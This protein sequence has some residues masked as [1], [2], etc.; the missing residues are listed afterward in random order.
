MHEQ[1]AQVL[2][3]ASLIKCS[4]QEAF[5]L[6]VT[7]KFCPHGL[8]H[9]LGIQVHDVGG[10]LADEEGRSAPPPDNYPSLRTTRTIEPNQVFT[11]EPGLYFIDS[12]LGELVEQGAPI[13]WDVVNRLRDYGGIRIE[14]NVRVLERGVENLTRDAWMRI[15]TSGRDV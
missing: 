15:A 6:G 11:I 2:V 14:D 3:E 7:E 13:N 4:A 1:L 9:L 12:L 8:G 10:H 5:A